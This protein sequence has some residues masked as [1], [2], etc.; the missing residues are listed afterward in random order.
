V[1]YEAF[2]TSGGVGTLCETLDGVVRNL[3]YKTIRY[4]GHLEMVRMLAGDLK[5]CEHRETFKKLIEYGVPVTQQ[6]VVLIYVSVTGMCKGTLT[7]E[8]YTKKIYGDTH[9]GGRS[10]IQKTT[11]AGVCAVVDLHRSGRMPHPGFLRQEEVDFD[12][13]I[14][15]RFGKVYA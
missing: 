7:Q 10:A 11:A 15:N 13:F 12:A 6:D 2:S 4:P 3:G 1:D 8:S 5:L 9:P 14:A